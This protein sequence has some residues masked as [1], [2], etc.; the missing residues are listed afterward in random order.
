MEEP[1]SAKD[2]WRAA[3]G[4]CAGTAGVRPAA[5]NNNKTNKNKLSGVGWYHDPGRHV[6]SVNPLF[7]CRETLWPHAASAG[8]EGR[9]AAGGR[10]AGGEGEGGEV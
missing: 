1:S 2:C 6:S 9:V 8:R 7:V 3:R 4:T 5:K 10:G